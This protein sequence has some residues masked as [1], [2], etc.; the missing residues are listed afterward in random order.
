MTPIHLWLVDDSPTVAA[1][2]AGWAE[3]LGYQLTAMASGQ[4]LCQLLQEGDLPLDLIIIDDDL[5]G[6]PTCQT[7]RQIRDA[8][9]RTE[10]PIFAL[11]DEFNANFR[12]VFRLAGGDGWLDSPPEKEQLQSLVEMVREKK[13][14]VT[15]ESRSINFRVKMGRL[16]LHW[17]GERVLC[18]GSLDENAGFER[19]ERIL[20]QDQEPIVID[21]AEVPTV[22][23]AGVQAWNSFVTDEFGSERKFR[24]RRCPLALL[25]FFNLMPEQFGDKV[26]VESLNIPVASHLD[27]A[28]SPIASSSSPS[29]TDGGLM[30]GIHKLIAVSGG[31]RECLYFSN[32]DP[33][34]EATPPTSG[35]TLTREYLYFL[36]TILRFSLS[37]FFITQQTVLDQASRLAARFS[38]FR[39]ALC[40]VGAEF[41]VPPADR[42]MMREVVI[43]SYEPIFASSSVS[44]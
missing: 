21:Y 40:S 1:K 8:F 23:L 33:I 42:R 11:S 38:C 31:Y 39:Q 19:L 25:E 32:L 43:D 29:S 10:V 35:K 16:G 41:L 15:N 6:V 30:S 22:N 14:V 34:L 7:V 18:C 17:D 28:V 24:F 9:C 13:V 44:N 3:E 2:F 20:P 4:A 12:D 26:E 36:H 5:P 37:E 27:L